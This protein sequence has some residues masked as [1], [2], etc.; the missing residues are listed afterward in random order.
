M[1]PCS[2]DLLGL[3]CRTSFA[4]SRVSVEESQSERIEE[5]VLICLGNSHGLGAVVAKISYLVFIKGFHID[6]IPG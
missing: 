6:L 3:Q 1:Y 4:F 5:G 2:S